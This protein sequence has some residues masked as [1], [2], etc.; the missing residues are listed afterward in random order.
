M[1]ERSVDQEEARKEAILRL[2]GFNVVGSRKTHQL[3]NN[4]TKSGQELMETLIS[5]DDR[6]FCRSSGYGW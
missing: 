5:K 2:K 4:S 3:I 1:A 6:F